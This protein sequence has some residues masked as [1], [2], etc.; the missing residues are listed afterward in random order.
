M[1]IRMLILGLIH[2]AK[3]NEEGRDCSRPSSIPKRTDLKNLCAFPLGCVNRLH[4]ND[5]S[6]QTAFLCHTDL[7]CIFEIFQIFCISY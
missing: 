7:Y 5:T 4:P 3:L 6:K 1:D 2:T